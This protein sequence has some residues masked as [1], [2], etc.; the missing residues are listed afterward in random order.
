METNPTTP[1]NPPIPQFARRKINWP[2][3]FAVMLAPAVVTIVA[4]LLGAKQGDTAPTI[5]VLGS[6]GSGIICGTMLGRRFG[7]T[8]GT[9]I[10]LGIVFA[11]VMGAAC[12]AMSCFGCLTSGYKLNFG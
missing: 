5:A 3:F 4:I 10:L 6:V 12:V 7:G 1:P 8:G 11:F 9:K 2:M